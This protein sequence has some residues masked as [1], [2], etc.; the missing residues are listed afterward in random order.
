MVSQLW[1]LMKLLQMANRDKIMKKLLLI[2]LIA[3]FAVPSFV[4]AGRH[5]N[6]RKVERTYTDDQC[7]DFHKEWYDISAALWWTTYDDKYNYDRIHALE[8]RRGEYIDK[9]N[10]CRDQG[11]VFGATEREFES[12]PHGMVT[13]VYR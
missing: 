12:W 3:L 9:L 2:C 13:N 10:I 4:D 6:P 8:G 7:R 1:H 5:K 11:N